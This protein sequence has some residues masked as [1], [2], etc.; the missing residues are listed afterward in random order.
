VTS[1][2]S[3]GDVDELK[4][5]GFVGINT[6]VSWWPPTANVDVD[7]V[8]TPLLT[9]IGLPRLNVPSLNCTVPTTVAGVTVAIRVTVVPWDTGEA[10]FVVSAVLVA[11]TPLMVAVPVTTKSTGG[12]VEEVNAAGLVGVNVAVSERVPTTNFDVDPTAV[13]LTTVTGLPRVV[14]PSLNWTVPGAVAG[15]IVT[16][17][18]TG[19]P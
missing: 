3:T 19:V 16:V 13:P 2:A 5:A 8:A 6:A 14:V 15:V 4:T 17:S 18:V 12:D 9:T 7:P 11:V 10:G 1:N